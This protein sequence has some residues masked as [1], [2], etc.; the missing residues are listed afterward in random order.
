WHDIP[1]C[2]EQGIGAHYLMLRGILM[3]KGVKP[4]VVQYYV[5][6]LKRVRETPEWKDFVNRGAYKEEF[7]TDGQFAKFLE[8]DEK[9]H[10]DI[11]EAAGFL[12]K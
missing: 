6:L 7:L 12:A 9:R 4:E 10:H 1:T 8:Q 11:M 5:D 2:K 3:P